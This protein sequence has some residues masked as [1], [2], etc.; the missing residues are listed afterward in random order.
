[1][2]ERMRTKRTFLSAFLF[3]VLF[4]SSAIATELPSVPDDARAEG[5][6]DDRAG[7]A[8][9][10]SRLYLDST[11]VSPGQ[12]VRIGVVMLPDEHWH[13]YWR[14]SG[15]SGLATRV[16]YK[17]VDLE[18][19]KASPMSWP[20]PEVFYL[21]KGDITTFGYEVR[22]M[23]AATITLPENLDAEQVTFEATADYLTCKVECIPGNQ[24]MR[25]T[26]P[27]AKERAPASKEVLALFKEHDARLPVSAKSAGV[28]LSVKTSQDKFRPGDDVSAEVKLDLCA[29]GKEKKDCA[30]YELDHDGEV[31]RAMIPDL[32]PMIEWKVAR[33]EVAEDGGA[34]TFLLTGDVAPGKRADKTRAAGV[35]KLRDLTKKKP[36]AVSFDHDIPTAD[37]GSKI[38]ATPLSL[39]APPVDPGEGSG[40]PEDSALSSTPEDAGA[41]PPVEPVSFLYALLLAFFGGMLLNVMPCVFPVLTLKVASIAQVAHK[42]RGSMLAHGLA[43][44]AGILATMQALAA[45]VI[46]MRLLGAQAGWG[47]QFQNPYFLLGLAG[48]LILFTANLFGAFE[49]DIPMGGKLGKVA[50]I[51]PGLK[52]SFAEGLLCVLL[53]TPCSAP[54]MGTA[55]GFALSAS[56]LEIL[57]IFSMLGIGLALPFVAL[58]ALPA[59][60]KLLPKPGPWLEHLKHLLAFS[61]LATTIWLVWLVGQSFGANGMAVSLVFLVAVAIGAWMFGLVQ[62]SAGAFKKRAAQ[63]IAIAIVGLAGAWAYQ[64][65]SSDVETSGVAAA[66]NSSDGIDWE[67][68]D[69]ERIA[70]TLAA[71][72][73]VFVDFTADWCITCKVNERTVLAQE[74]VLEAIAEN[75]VVMFK[76]D[77]TRRDERIRAILAR[78]NKGGV[79]MYLV[80]SPSRP[81]TPEV[82][83]ELL[84]ESLVIDSMRAAKK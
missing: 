80:Y 74:P 39:L 72:K 31:T 42:E 35:I 63:L 19:A 23:H 6:F 50:D 59:W 20:A 64:L 70:K 22:V 15:D 47:F 43:Y 7:E 40:A 79:P 57:A 13:T 51:E 56:P 25:V 14:N 75:D 5:A 58:C 33:V 3:L 62:Y 44:S 83:P 78:Y 84:T 45:V 16:T 12:K 36:L 9:V 1:M 48:I 65:F 53:A 68:F 2:F 73:P 46:A 10:E 76:A 41:A 67:P 61:L 60:T 11:S 69:E 55:V 32:A 17:A 4:T 27:V 26:V 21:E 77:W 49:F 8:R 66:S 30:R 37:K 71:G 34:V 81:E 29:K 38:E 24:T 28:T 54:F 82:L 52:Q 18:D